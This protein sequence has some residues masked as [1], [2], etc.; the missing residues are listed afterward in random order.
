MALAFKTINRVSEV[1]LPVHKSDKSWIA[2][3]GKFFVTSC[4]E[5]DVHPPSDP[6]KNYC[7]NSS[8]RRCYKQNN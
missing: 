7:L 3:L 8:L 1:A 2:Q 4:T 5:N 6:K